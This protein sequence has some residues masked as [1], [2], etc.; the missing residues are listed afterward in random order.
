MGV[1]VQVNP[2]DLVNP[3]QADRKRWYLGGWR[4]ERIKP[5]PDQKPI[6]LRSD[7][8]FGSYSRVISIG[9]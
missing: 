1:V 9:T 5:T 4:H 2:V 8:S 3:L 6:P 7:A